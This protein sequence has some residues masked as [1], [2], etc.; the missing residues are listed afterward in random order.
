[1]RLLYR[2]FGA[3][4]LAIYSICRIFNR[5]GVSTGRSGRDAIIAQ[6]PPVFKLDGIIDKTRN[7]NCGR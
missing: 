3:W 7:V 5:K 4:L 2:Y 1:M 6:P